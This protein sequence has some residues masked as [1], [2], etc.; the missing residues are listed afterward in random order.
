MLR[1]FCLSLPSLPIHLSSLPPPHLQSLSQC[2]DGVG[3]CPDTEDSS[4]EC[5]NNVALLQ[6]W[7]E[8]GQQCVV[9]SR[10]FTAGELNHE[11]HLSVCLSVCPS[12]CPSI[13]LPVCLSVCL[14][15]C[16]HALVPSGLFQVMTVTG[17]WTQTMSSSI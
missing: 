5:S 13:C 6:G 1:H 16:H 11:T 2:R 14:S 15:V 8:N 12:I 9:Y 7:K 3:A 17:C 4:G 10:N